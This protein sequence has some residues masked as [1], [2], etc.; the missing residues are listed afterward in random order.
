MDGAKAAYQQAIDSGHADV[1]ADGR[2]QPGDLLAGPGRRGRREGRLPAGHR[3]RG[4]RLGAEAAVDLGICC[5]SRG[6]WTA[7]RPPTSRPSTPGTPTRRRRP[8]STWGLLL[9]EQGDADGAKAAYQQAIDSGHADV[10]AEGRG[11]PGALLSEQGD[12][13]GAKAAY[14]QAIDSGHAERRRRPRSTWGSAQEQG[15][16]DGAKAAYQQAIDSGHADEAPTAAINLGDLLGSRVTWTGAKAA[17]Q[18]AIDSGHADAAA[19]SAVASGRCS[20][21]KGIGRAR[22]RPSDGPAR[23]SA[24]PPPLADPQAVTGE[25]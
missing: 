20:G 1:G 21:S 14:Q 15:D 16:A 4:R 13:D 18:Q 17:Y 7:R 8:R 6:T 25:D 12:V 11:Q 24:G 22:G 19:A 23:V 9:Q 5:R 10:G 2:G 3:L